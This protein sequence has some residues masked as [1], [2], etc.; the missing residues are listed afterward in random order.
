MKMLT[1]SVFLLAF[2]A[3]G[4]EARADFD[5]TCESSSGQTRNCPIN[6]SY[7]SVHLKT[8]LSR[9]SCFEG[10]TWGTNDSYVWVSNGCRATFRVSQGNTNYNSYGNRYDSHESSDNGKATATAAAVIIGAAAI[11][12]ANNKN[13]N[14]GSYGNGYDRYDNNGYNNYGYNNSYGYNNNYGGNRGSVTC[15]S[16]DQRRQR[17]TLFVGRGSV[18]IS[19][20]LSSSSCR[21]G[22]D[23]DY[24]RNAVYVWNGCRA[25]FSVY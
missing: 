6:G 23:W 19:R 16:R 8:Q 10:S 21:F 18:R 1:L 2:S 20:K 22:Q 14:H 13:N 5:V 9:A 15:E 25:V 24:D 17:C 4:S 11:A 12:A 7:T 3:F